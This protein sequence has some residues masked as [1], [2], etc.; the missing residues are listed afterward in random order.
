MRGLKSK[1]QG[2]MCLYN[3]SE[4]GLIRFLNGGTFS[5]NAGAINIWNTAKVGFTDSIGNMPVNMWNRKDSGV[6]NF[7]LVFSANSIT[8]ATAYLVLDDPQTS[9]FN[10]STFNLLTSNMLMMGNY[11]LDIDPIY[12]NS[13]SIAGVTQAGAQVSIKKRVGRAGCCGW[14]Q[15]ILFVRCEPAVKKG[16]CSS[17]TQS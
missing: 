6:I 5:G 13:A 14:R 7:S 1:I 8:V 4:T 16:Y 10:A 9:E 2:D 3:A 15:R 11:Y 12:T 17:S